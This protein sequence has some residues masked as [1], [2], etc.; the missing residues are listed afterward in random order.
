MEFCS[1]YNIKF[2]TKDKREK[3]KVKKA[4]RCK[5]Y[6]TSTRQHATIQ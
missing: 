2:K 1:V 3:T 4:T 5:V 6:S